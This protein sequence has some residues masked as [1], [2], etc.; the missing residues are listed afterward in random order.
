MTRAVAGL[1]LGGAA[2]SGEASKAVAIMAGARRLATVIM[3]GSIPD[4]AESAIR[5][6]GTDKYTAAGAF[7]VSFACPRA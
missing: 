2:W 5:K 7:E 1:G 6:R 4:E 3:P